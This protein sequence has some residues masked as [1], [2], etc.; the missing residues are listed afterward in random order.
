MTLGPI[1][2]TKYMKRQGLDPNMVYEALVVNNNDERKF[3]RIQ[4]RI[5]GLFDGIADADLPWAVPTFNHVQG[6]HVS[7]NE[8]SGIAYVPRI[9]HKVGIKFP[10]ADAHKPMWGP[11]I[12]DAQ[13]AL[14][15]M[16]TNYP[17]RIV[18]HLDHGF[19]VI[20]DSRTNEVFLNNPGD[21]NMTILGDVN[22]YIVG[23]QQLVVTNNKNDIPG[24]LLNAPDTVL[25][26]LNAKPAKKINFSGLLSK[27]NAG[28]QHTTIT[29][30]QTV[31]VKGNRKIVV[32]GN[33]T[34]E[35][36]KN[37]IEKVAMTSRS[38]CQRSETNG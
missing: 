11:Y 6:T 36:K 12:T 15:S 34:L 21:W 22:Q 29:G 7:G 8:W 4:A 27:G 35:V 3:C 32:Q 14:P 18:F 38:E 2:A 13:T 37:K 25:K 19:Y 5:P 10:L 23:N 28:N 24:Y 31:L 16:A 17:D 1:N 30:D 20:I 33:D 26:N 9:G